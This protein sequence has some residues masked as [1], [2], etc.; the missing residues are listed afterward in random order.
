LN[1]NLHHVAIALFAALTAASP[2]LAGEGRIE[3]R[4]GY[5]KDVGPG[6]GVAGIA[7]GYDFDIGS[8]A[9]IGPEVSIDKVLRSG[10]EYL[11]GLTGRAGVKLGERGKLFV[12]GGVTPKSVEESPYRLGGGYEHRLGGNLYIKAEYRH[13]FAERSVFDSGD[14]VTAG[15]GFKF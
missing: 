14:S 4:G 15:V 13:Y 11:F 10:N 1:L 2:A 5:Y 12:A 8:Q 7:A 9:F 6:A 3:A